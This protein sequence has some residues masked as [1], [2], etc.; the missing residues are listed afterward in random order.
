[1]SPNLQPVTRQ[2]KSRLMEMAMSSG[3]SGDPSP[4]PA[5]CPVQIPFLPDGVPS[6]PVSN[7]HDN[8]KFAL[9]QQLILST[10]KSNAM[11]KRLNAYRQRRRIDPDVIETVSDN[12]A[13]DPMPD[14]SDFLGLPSKDVPGGTSIP[15][16]AV[17]GPDHPPTVAA[18]QS[19]L[20]PLYL[21]FPS[22]L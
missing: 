4:L 1:M 13:D 20:R 8:A 22:L 17:P 6:I 9:F 14:I 15:H 18:M 12:D 19:S 5:T 2:V 16:I 10:E 7:A 11:K 3:P 21:R